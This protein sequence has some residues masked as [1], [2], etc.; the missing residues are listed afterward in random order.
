MRPLEQQDPVCL[1]LGGTPG[2]S[3]GREAAE[4]LIAIMRGSVSRL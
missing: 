3:F 2:V 4:D 1:L